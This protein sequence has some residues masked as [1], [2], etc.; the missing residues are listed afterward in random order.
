MERLADIVDRDRIGAS[1]EKL[2]NWR[3]IIDHRGLMQRCGA[4]A[5]LNIE[6]GTTSEQAVAIFRQPCAQ[7]IEQRRRFRSRI[8][9][10]GIHAARQQFVEPE[11]VFAHGGQMHCGAA[12]TIR[13]GGIHALIEKLAEGAAV[14]FKHGSLQGGRVLRS[15]RRRRRTDQQIGWR[16]TR[17]VSFDRRP[18]YVPDALF[19]TAGRIWIATVDRCLE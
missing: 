14:L 15:G 6:V 9:D 13:L 7:R 11:P 18:F 4:V 1:F 5:I 19:S 3:R 10:I 2:Q 12:I 8:R 17:V 16:A